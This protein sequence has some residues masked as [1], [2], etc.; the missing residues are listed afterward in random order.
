[1]DQEAAA[2]STTTA[3]APAPSPVAAR[4]PHAPADPRRWTPWRV[5]G[6][7]TLVAVL[8]WAFV[9]V[10]WAGPNETWPVV[11]GAMWE[12]V[13]APDLAFVWNGSGEDLVGLIT[14]TLAIAFL[15]TAIAVI[16]AVP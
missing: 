12:G 16:G 3:S 9:G 4:A 14:Q 7:A 11:L 8:V 2:V 15:G 6:A 1:G 13:L 10:G 5:A